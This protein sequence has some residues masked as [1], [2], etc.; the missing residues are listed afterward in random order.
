MR[1]ADVDDL[2]AL[3]GDAEAMRFYP[4][5]LTREQADAWIRRNLERYAT[6]GHGLWLIETHDG[7]FVG[8]CGL[9]WQ[10]V[11]GTPRLEVGF[12]VT[13]AL[14]GFGYATEAA[15]ACRDL[16]RD[17]LRAHELLALVH[18]ENTASRRVAE[19]IGMTHVEDDHG[20]SI[21]L[22]LVMG[23]RWGYAAAHG[24]A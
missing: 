23:M 20:S 12:H 7:T 16:A 14:Q 9:T 17:V 3:L 6:D 10:P 2:A 1:P 22:R 21:P 15:T 5:P 8:D 4:V 18:P 24:G 13:R 11:N 19:R